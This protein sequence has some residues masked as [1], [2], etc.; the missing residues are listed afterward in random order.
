M[1]TP[2]HFYVAA[3]NA[4]LLTTFLAVA[5]ISRLSI[6]SYEAEGRGKLEKTSGEGGQGYQI[7]EIVL[8]PRIAVSTEADR[9]RAGRLIEK[10]EKSCLISR[11]M[12]T[13]IRLEPEIVVK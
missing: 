6:V 2:E 13:L 7:T 12:K 4:C 11:S 5:E 1:W 10:A 9:E 8:Q 3:A